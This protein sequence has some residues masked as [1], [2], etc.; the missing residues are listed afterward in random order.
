MCLCSVT[1]EVAAAAPAVGRLPRD[2][3]G[4]VWPACFDGLGMNSLER[5]INYVV[6]TQER[7][8]LSY[9]TERGFV[10]SSY[11]KEFVS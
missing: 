7:F 8:L 9:S 10:R 1:A 5:K 2:L 4:V 11:T 3:I 6:R